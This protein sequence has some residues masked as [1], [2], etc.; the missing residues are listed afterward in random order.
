M[1]RAHVEKTLMPLTEP[2]NRFIK[3][4]EDA[5]MRRDD[6][7]TEPPPTPQQPED[8]DDI[9]LDVEEEARQ[10]KERFARQVHD[11]EMK[12]RLRAEK[13]AERVGKS[14]RRLEE[15]FE[16]EGH[17]VKRPYSELNV[18]MEHLPGDQPIP[19]RPI[20]TPLRQ[21]TTTTQG[22]PGGR[23]LPYTPL[24]TV[25]ES[26]TDIQMLLRTPG[27]RLE[28]ELVLKTKFSG[29]LAREYLIGYIKD[30]R[31]EYDTVFGPRIEGSEFLL[32]DKRM[33]FNGDDIVLAFPG[34]PDAFDETDGGKTYAGTRGL[35]EL[36]FKKE[37]N[38]HVYTAD[39]LVSY[40]DVLL[41][42]NVHRR[43]YSRLKPIKSSQNAKYKTVIAKIFRH[44]TA[45]TKKGTGLQKTEDLTMEVRE[46]E[47][48]Q[49]VYYDDPNELCERLELLVQSK[50]VGNT[51]H[52]NEINSIVE[53]LLEAGLILRREAAA[54]GC[55][56][57]QQ[58]TDDGGFREQWRQP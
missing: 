37:P 51:G 19:G 28:A 30:T 20:Y 4:V 47:R 50:E 3:T 6:V 9:M 16:E 29:L 55:Q 12:R 54:K 43:D 49:Y 7:K 31:G 14:K 39:D 26:P 48:T 41:T 33:R 40:T 36:I 42:T 25:A 44:P 57:Q 56:Q 45:A 24:Q 21:S 17:R 53:E 10:K 13:S 5:S 11:A 15:A 32:G 27:G 58:Q 35:Y 22:S 2:L 46:G 8:G 1:S 34:E 18:E 23:P 52:D 38:D